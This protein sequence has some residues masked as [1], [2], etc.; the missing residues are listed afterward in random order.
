LPWYDRLGL[1]PCITTTPR[2]KITI[3]DLL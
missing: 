1:T 2:T 3:P